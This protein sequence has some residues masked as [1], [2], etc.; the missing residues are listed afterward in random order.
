MRYINHIFCLLVGLIIGL[1]LGFYISAVDFLDLSDS[2][3]ETEEVSEGTYS[4][5]KT[6]KEGDEGFDAKAMTLQSYTAD[7]WDYATIKNNTDKVIKEYTYRIIFY[8]MKGN[9]L[10]Y[11]DN[12][13][14]KEIEPQMSRTDSHG[15]YESSDYAYYKTSDNYDKTHKKLYTIKYELKSYTFK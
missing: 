15:G 8:D 12:I 1:G 6:Y 10:D 3:T 4:I 7:T 11:K 2:T 5:K 13:V 9:M 14:K